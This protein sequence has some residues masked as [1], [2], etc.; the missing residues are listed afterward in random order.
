MSFSVAGVVRG[1]AKARPDD[2]MLSFEGNKTTW[3]EHDCRSSKVGQA[4]RAAGVRR[5]D[6]VAYLDKNGPGYFEILFGGAK[7]NAVNVAVN[8]R[9]APREMAQIIN[10]S[11]ARLL[12]VGEEFVGH[13]DEMNS[14][15]T[16]VTETVVMSEGDHG[17]MSYEEWVR[18]ASDEDPGEDSAPSDVAMQ[19][20]TSGTTGLPKGAMLTNANIGALV[21]L[22]AA[23]FGLGPSS[24]SMIAMPLFHIGGS[25]WALLGMANGASSVILREV[26]ADL[27]LEVIET[28][29]VTH[30]FIVPAVV[31]MLLASPRCPRTDF[32]SLRMV[33]YGAS[34]ISESVLVRALETFGCEFAQLYGL[35]E[36][37]GAITMLSPADHEPGGPRANRLRSCG[38]PFPHV[39]IR[40]VDPSTGLDRPTGE[41]G[42]IWT[43]SP[44]N[45]A[46][47]WH[48]PE[49]TAKTI[50]ADGWLRTGDA[51][52][53]DADGFLYLHDRVKDVIVSGGENIYP[54][55]VENVLMGHP[56]VADAA[57]I[58]VPDER[59]GET[60]KAVVVPEGG[61]A[62][63]PGEIIAFAR[64]RLAHYKC[65]TS[66]DVVEALPR[67]PS[68][69]VLKRELREPYWRGLDRRIH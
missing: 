44:Q 17:R 6:R 37:T 15:L 22:A 30:T 56:A 42:E 25:G 53:I 28:S 69:K 18:G 67:N 10:D 27:V 64:E 60:V 32:S 38:V 9:L 51:G 65:P 52:Y 55:E 68:G 11:G 50:T 46:G 3:V 14:A 47:Y 19:L 62:P 58:G 8:W 33:T 43:A 36:T 16:T 35:T 59:W 24:V 34:P 5:Q 12:F 45:M 61:S 49:E 2:I 66:V 63:V 13:L 54:A 20:Y 39:R 41:V 1:Q 31:M 57:V 21:P 40:V 23:N 48:A 7:I 26:D 29:R 4:L